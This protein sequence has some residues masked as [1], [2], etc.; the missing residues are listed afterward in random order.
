MLKD[1]LNS[2]KEDKIP[3]VVITHANCWDGTGAATAVIEYCLKNNISSPTLLRQQYGQEVPNIENSNVLLLDFSFPKDV[4][5]DLNSKNNDMFII[6]HHESARKDLSGIDFCHFDMSH[7]AAYLAWDLLLGYVPDGIRYIED[8]DIWKW[9][10][11]N[12]KA[13]SAGLQ[14]HD[15]NCVLTLHIRLK[16]DDMLVNMCIKSGELIL[17]YQEM[18]VDKTKAKLDDGDIKLVKFFGYTVP[19][20]NNSNLISEIGNMLCQDHPFS[21]Q[22]F[23]TKDKIVFSFR[24]NGLVNLTNLKIPRGHPNAAGNSFKL[25]SIDLNEVF[26]CEDLGKYLETII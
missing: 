26:K 20:F 13:F 21:I 23:F 10:L 19:L 1:F 15:V 5:L 12:S 22:Y 16:H 9:E 17:Q 25:D 6:D 8:R 24:A 4:L 18:Q 14:L 2:V 7:S 3:F 11:H